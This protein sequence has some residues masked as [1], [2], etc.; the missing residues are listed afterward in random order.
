MPSLH[1]DELGLV[2]RRRLDGALEKDEDVGER[3]ERGLGHGGPAG[4][5]ASIEAAQRRG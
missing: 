5:G 3:G 2:G 4:A 1:V